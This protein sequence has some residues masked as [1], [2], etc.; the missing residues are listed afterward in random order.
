[1]KKSGGINLGAEGR[2]SGKNK[3]KMLGKN[4]VFF[5]CNNDCYCILLE[6]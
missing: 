6:V 3:F 1:M 4:K 2:L 5:C